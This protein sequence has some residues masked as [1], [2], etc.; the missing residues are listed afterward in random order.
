M[1]LLQAVYDSYLP[2]FLTVVADASQARDCDGRTLVDCHPSVPAGADNLHVPPAFPYPV[3]RVCQYI[4]LLHGLPH[5]LR[6]VF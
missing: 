6:L 2:L 4:S 1:H 3:L 5:S